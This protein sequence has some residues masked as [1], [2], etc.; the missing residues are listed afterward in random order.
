MDCR[1][2]GGDEGR[3]K[4]DVLFLDDGVPPRTGDAE[5]RFTLH[6]L[7]RLLIASLRNFTSENSDMSSN[8]SS[9]LATSDV[10]AAWM[11]DLRKSAPNV[12]LVPV[13][14]FI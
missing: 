12:G 5:W 14:V 8:I 1:R 7:G 11:S 2:L 6:D 10:L 4:G 9:A 13:S 3:A